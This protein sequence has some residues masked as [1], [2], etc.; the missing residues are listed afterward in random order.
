MSTVS[1]SQRRIPGISRLFSEYLYDFGKVARFYPAGA[2]FDCD[3]LT[4]AA[5]ALRFPQVRRKAL[6]RMLA[7]QN[8]HWGPEGKSPLATNGLIERLGEP[9]TVAIVTG[10]QVGLFGGPLLG[11]LKAMSAVLV[12]ERLRQRGVSAVPIFWMATP[13]HDLAE[14]NQAWALDAASSV[15]CFKADVHSEAPAPVGRMRLPESI[16][17]VEEAWDQAI[18]A[19]PGPEPAALRSAYAPGATFADAYAQMFARWFAPWGLILFD[20]MQAPEAAEPWR[21]LYQA[22][23][24]RHA[25]LGALLRQR[26]EDLENGGYH[27]QVAQSANASMLFLHRD[28]A[29]I[30][31]RRQ[32]DAWLIGDEPLSDAEL[33][34]WLGDHPSDVSASALLRPVL[35]DALFPTVAQVAGPAETAYLAQSAVLYQ[36]LGV[37]QPVAWPRAS[38]TLLDAKA[39]RLLEKNGLSFDEAWHTSAAELLARKALPPG[40][41]RR[42]RDLHAAFDREFEA[43]AGELET[44]DPTLVDAAQGAVQKIRHQL[45]QLEARVA[46]SLARRSGEIVSQAQHLDALLHPNGSLQERVLATAAFAARY[47][48]LCGQ[49]HDA[50]DVTSPEHHALEL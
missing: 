36:A 12:A 41:E 27:I 28:G 10:Q 9:D 44:L 43:L 37:R 13:D 1:V 17:A 5:Q 14:V 25:E 42:A 49:L 8:E 50:L 24:G 23:A 20:P 30:G 2:P 26:G 33:N 16:V 21:P 48:G 40:A 35:Q 39:R 18:T 34:S 47:P 6:V 7:R 3:R 32:N 19:A 15:Q 11:F 22:A 38:A 45:E 46:R 29:R 4:R 31:L